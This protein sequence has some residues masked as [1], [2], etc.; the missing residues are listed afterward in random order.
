MAKP[1]H[2][3]DI[4]YVSNKLKAMQTQKAWGELTIKFERGVMQIINMNLHFVP[5]SNK[6]FDSQEIENF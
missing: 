2:K 6:K 4:E 1:E 5:P 3:I